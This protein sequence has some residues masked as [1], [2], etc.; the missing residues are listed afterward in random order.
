MREQ[1]ISAIDNFELNLGVRGEDWVSTPGNTWV[2]FDN[3]DVALFEDRENGVFEGHLL[4]V[5]RGREA[6]QNAKTAFRT[7]LDRGNVKVLFGLVPDD[8][9]ATKLVCRWAGTQSVGIRETSNGPCEMFVLTSA[10]KGI[11]E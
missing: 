1:V 6:I 11:V 9:R 10:M 7:M 8:R 2:A 3:G 5:S 4:F